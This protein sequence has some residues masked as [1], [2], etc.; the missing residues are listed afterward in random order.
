MK[1]KVL[2]FGTAVNESMRLYGTVIAA[3]NIKPALEDIYVDMIR[4]EGIIFDSQGRRGGGSWK[5]LKE[6]TIRK[7][8]STRL[9]FTADANYHYKELKGPDLLAKSM[10]ERGAQYQVLHTDKSHIVFGTDRP[11]AAVHQRGKASRGIPARPFLRF[12]PV[13]ERRWANMIGRWV[14]A[15]AFRP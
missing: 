15:P 8:G 7:K 6:E 14:V 12:L 10:T 13:D 2:D 1:L 11:Y 3:Q 4:V 5:R 9:L